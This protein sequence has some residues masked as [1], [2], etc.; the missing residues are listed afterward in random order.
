M[1]ISAKR[2]LASMVVGVMIASAFAGFLVGGIA[3]AQPQPLPCALDE[4]FSSSWLPSGWAEDDWDL[5]FLPN[6]AGGTAPEARLYGDEISGDGAYLDSKPVDTS[7]VS[8][9]TLQFKSFILDYCCSYNGGQDEYCDGACGSYNCSVY[10]RADVG[11][12]W[13]DVTPWSNPI[14]GPVGPDTYSLDIS[15]DIGNATQVRFEFNGYDY[16]INYW[17]VDD[18]KICGPVPDLVVSITSVT[19]DEYGNFTVSYNVTNQGTAATDWSIPA[20]YINGINVEARGCPPLVPG[21]SWSDTFWPKSYP[22]PCDGTFEVMVCADDWEYYQES[23]EGNNCDTNTVAPPCPDLVVSVTSV[24]FDEYGNFTVS[25][26]VTN[27][28]TAPAGSSNTAKYVDGVWQDYESCPSLGPGD[29]HNG[30]FSSEPCSDFASCGGTFNVTGCADDDGEVQ[31]SEENNNCEMNVVECPCPK[32]VDPKQDSLYRDVDGNGAAS[33]GDILQY[34]A[35]IRNEGNAAATGVTFNDTVDANT[36][37]MCADPYAP[38]TS[39]GSITSCNSA[40]GGSLAADLG[41]IC[42]KDKVTV[43]FYVRVGYGE[44]DRVSNQGLLTGD[45]FADDPTD[46]PDTSEPDD[47]T[48]TP[49]PQLGPTPPPAV[50]TVNQWGIVAMIAVFTALLVWMV[51]RRL[52]AS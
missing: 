19:F 42:P 38:I 30:T 28:G 31:E 8:S 45:N 47:P 51:R 52:S 14:Y 25:Y 11:D 37:L 17:A 21:E 33:S 48:D 12:S 15:S 46:D 40:P 6:G 10:T 20:E 16:A 36:I 50:P 22:C 5:S 1:D 13:T 2:L 35:E 9:L 41:D 29:S 23:D 32:I 3:L 26:N 24:T 39:Q 34:I 43:T 4:D 49:I 7:A 27:Q 44:F 18:V